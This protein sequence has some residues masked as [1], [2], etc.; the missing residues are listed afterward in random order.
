MFKE[1]DLFPNIEVKTVTLETFGD[2]GYNVDIDL[3]LEGQLFE[4]AETEQLDFIKNRLI[5]DSALFADNIR[6]ISKQKIKSEF[7]IDEAENIFTILE[8]INYKFENEEDVQNLRL[9][10]RPTLSSDD[11]EGYELEDLYGDIIEEILIEDGKV[12]SSKLQDFTRDLDQLE[13]A[14]PFD[15]NFIENK[16]LSNELTQLKP[17]EVITSLLPELPYLNLMT[18][19]DKDNRAKFVILVD[20]DGIM[21]TKSRFGKLYDNADDD[22]KERLVRMTKINALEI[23]RKKVTG[24]E[25]ESVILS[26][27]GERGGL[28]EQEDE[29]GYIGELIKVKLNNNIRTFNATDKKTKELNGGSY[30]YIVELTVTDGTVKYL[31]SELRVLRVM[32]NQLEEYLTIRNQ[33][34]VSPKEIDSFYRTNIQTAIQFYL[35]LMSVFGGNVLVREI[36]GKLEQITSPSFDINGLERV[37]A[38]FNNLLTVIERHVTSGGKLDKSDSVTVSGTTDTSILIRKEFTNQVFDIRQDQMTGYDYLSIPTEADEGQTSGIKIITSAIMKNRAN[39][40]TN[41]LFADN[42]KNFQFLWKTD[43]GININP[44]SVAYSAY[45]YLAP[46][47][48]KLQGTAELNPIGAI[49]TK[50]IAQKSLDMLMNVFVYNSLDDKLLPETN[51]K[52]KEMK[53][54]AT[55]N[56]TEM[57]N[58]MGVTFKNVTRDEAKVESGKNYSMDY[59]E[60]QTDAQEEREEVNTQFQ[61]LM[62][63]AL[64]KALNTTFTDITEYEALSEDNLLNKNKM[65]KEDVREIP[66]HIKALFLTPAQGTKYDWHDKENSL[67]QDLSNYGYFWMN[68]LNLVKVEVLDSVLYS[69]DIGRVSLT[70]KSWRL[71]KEGDLATRKDKL[72]RIVQYL[73]DRVG[74]KYQKEFELPIYDEYF[75]LKAK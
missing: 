11:F 22:L 9:Q 48:V 8:R 5:I 74:I 25:E 18:A 51:Q 35:E 45:S 21:K 26:S 34:L 4:L 39:I 56:I 15:F 33:K 61:P 59:N 64:L 60:Q 30:H 3:K 24:T 41:L 37:I 70:G 42:T 72:C 67:F 31:Q 57:Y 44:D 19:R 28:I 16:L 1:S 68:Y 36:K 55:K 62:Y 7:K 75:V 23:I 50:E 27:D 40:E 52:P 58:R 20:Y 13:Q 65:S 46:S 73:D 71:L 2:I 54:Q 6:L 38:A 63:S 10:I 69:D 29:K 66:N 14:I 32:V 47:K 17:N 12:M 49:P 43:E 53:L